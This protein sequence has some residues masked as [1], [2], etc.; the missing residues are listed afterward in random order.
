MK[1]SERRTVH[2]TSAPEPFATIGKR[3]EKEKSI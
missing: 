3:R 2:I 1:W